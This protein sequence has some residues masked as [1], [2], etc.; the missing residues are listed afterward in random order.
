M[1][2]VVHF[3]D[4]ADGPDSLLFALPVTL[5]YGFTCLSAYYICRSF[6]LVDK[7]IGALLVVMLANSTVTALLWDGLALG[8]SEVLT[9]FGFAITMPKSLLATL[10]GIG[11]VLFMLSIVAHYLMITFE[12]ARQAERRGLETDLLAREAEL[13]L[14]RAQ[15]DPHFIFNSLNSI[16]AL[17]TADPEGAR[18]MTLLLA[19]FLR[20]SLKAAS[21]NR[22]SVAEELKLNMNFLEI[23]RVRF[24][25]RLRIETEIAKDAE[26]CLLP[27][28]I[29]QPLVENAVKHGIG[30]SL[31][32][33]IVRIKIS[34]NGDQLHAVVE[35][36]VDEPV[37]GQ[38]RTGVGLANI[39]QRLTAMYGDD[40]ILQWGVVEKTFRAEIKWPAN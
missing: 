39:Q 40:A 18:T 14:L 16:S 1:A 7:K 25:S 13:R 17:T 8:W 36:P 29:L 5:V 4:N 2:L 26:N 37:A 21:E 20:Q 15:I 9:Q 12:Q 28:L 30:Q 34:R 19:D 11:V 23:E 10:F 35:N 32:G 24:G 27:P 33:G 6:P 22:I 31:D 3:S 38:N